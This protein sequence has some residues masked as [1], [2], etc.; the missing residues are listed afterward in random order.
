MAKQNYLDT[1]NFFKRL[2]GK[3]NICKQYYYVNDCLKHTVL[4]YYT[5]KTSKYLL[6]LYI[7][8][9]NATLRACT[10]E[11]GL[12]TFKVNK[13]QIKT[14]IKLCFKQLNKKLIRKYKLD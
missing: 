9:D 14:I 8:K 7:T 3:Y 4:V 2:K 11:N 6:S 1:I 13:I 12:R 5:T 10:P